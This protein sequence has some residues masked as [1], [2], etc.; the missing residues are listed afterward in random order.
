M[1]P[2]SLKLLGHSNV[3]SGVCGEY[4]VRAQQVIHPQDDIIE[5]LCVLL[6]VQMCDVYCLR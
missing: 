1:L 3:G 5:A 6:D 4:L 2:P